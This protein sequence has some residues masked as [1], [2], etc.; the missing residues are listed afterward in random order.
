MNLALASKYVC[1]GALVPANRI[2]WYFRD[3][4]GD[5]LLIYFWYQRECRRATRMI[6]EPEGLALEENKK[7]QMLLFIG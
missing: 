1:T 7:N 3:V 4:K 6:K 2:L 5:D